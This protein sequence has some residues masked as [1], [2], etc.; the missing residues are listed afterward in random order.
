MIAADVVII[1]SGVEHRRN[2]AVE[3]EGEM[4]VDGVGNGG[5]ESSEVDRLMMLRK[6]PARRR[7]VAACRLLFIGFRHACVQIEVT[8]LY[9]ERG[10]GF[11]VFIRLRLSRLPRG[12]PIIVRRDPGALMRRGGAFRC[13]R[14]YFGSFRTLRGVRAR[15]PEQK[16]GRQCRADGE[17]LTLVHRETPPVALSRA[18]GENCR[19]PVRLFARGVRF[20]DETQIAGYC[21]SVPLIRYRRRVYLYFY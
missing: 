15:R 16:S 11:R 5:D 10:V 3:R 18:V 14:R 8:G 21:N 17:T 6:S 1:V 4:G 2:G 20:S 19:V 9:F 7:I 13:A 12:G